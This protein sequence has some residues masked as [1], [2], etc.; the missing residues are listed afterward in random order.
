MST[1]EPE[2]RGIYSGVHKD[3][4]V[5]AWAGRQGYIL[6][7]THTKTGHSVAFPGNITTFQDSHA[8]VRKMTKIW[9]QMDPEVK[10]QN[11]F[12]KVSFTFLVVNGSLDEARHNEQNLNLLLCMMY[13]IWDGTRR[14]GSTIR[15]KGLNFLKS[16]RP[17]D[18]EGAERGIELWISSL[19][20]SLDLDAGVITSKGTGIFGEDEIYPTQIAIS[21]DGDVR[22]HKWKRDD[23]SPWPTVFPKYR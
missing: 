10:Q 1:L 20:Y 13:P 9:E 3:K 12:R 2:H 19:Q 14:T 21:I 23:N 6:K 8:S 22:V 17:N 15:A 18:A 11:A 4:S 16:S 5:S 7:F